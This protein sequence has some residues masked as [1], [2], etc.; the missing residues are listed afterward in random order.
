MDIFVYSDESGVFDKEHNSFYTFGGVVF[1]GKEQR[2]ECSRKYIKAERDV[3]TAEKIPDNQEVKACIISNK[4]KGK[5]YRSLNQYYKF[6]AIVR[7]DRVNENIY[8]SKKDKQCYL[9]YVYKIAVKRLFE[10]L[11]E[12]KVVSADEVEKICFL[13]DEHTTATNGRYELREGLEREFKR[14]TFNGN[15]GIWFPPIFRDIQSVDLCYCNSAKKTLVRAADI[16][17]NHVLYMARNDLPLENDARKMH[18]TLF[19]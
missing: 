14:G 16:V 13:T 10:K 7:E 1:I 3:R 12:G 15:Y 9:D 17:A 8:N 19:P 18:I 6:G 4:S 2:D 11:I 5:L